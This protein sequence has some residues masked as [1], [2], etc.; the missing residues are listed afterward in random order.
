MKLTY[1]KINEE[2]Y[3]VYEETTGRVIMTCKRAFNAHLIATILQ[4]DE[5]GEISKKVMFKE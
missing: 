2:L 4:E 5:K 3:A 1:K